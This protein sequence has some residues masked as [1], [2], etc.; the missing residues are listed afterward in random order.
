MRGA[1][2]RVIDFDEPKGNDWLAV[3]QFSVTENEHS[4]RPDVVLFV[5]GPPLAVVAHDAA[6]AGGPEAN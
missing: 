3:N 6:I 5:N 1:Q 2:A 4:R